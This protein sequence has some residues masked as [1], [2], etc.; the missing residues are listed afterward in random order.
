MD[1]FKDINDLKAIQA[2]QQLMN[3]D[4]GDYGEA[5]E[6]ED[7]EY[8]EQEFEAEKPQSS[9]VQDRHMPQHAPYDSEADYMEEEPESENDIKFIDDNGGNNFNLDEEQ[10]PSQDEESEQ[11]KHKP[12]QEAIKESAEEDRLDEESEDEGYEQKFSENLIGLGS[13]SSSTPEEAKPAESYMKPPPQKE[14]NEDEYFDQDEE[15]LEN[16]AEHTEQGKEQV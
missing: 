10:E 5:E 15:Y 9:K 7:E 3:R 4:S 1:S 12:Q 14:V 16:E 2:T 8:D 6:D 13:E 11:P